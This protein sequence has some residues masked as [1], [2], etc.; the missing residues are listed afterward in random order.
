MRHFDVLD[1]QINQRVASMAKCFFSLLPARCKKSPFFRNLGL[2]QDAAPITAGGAPS[3]WRWTWGTATPD[4]G[5]GVLPPTTLSPT[6][7]RPQFWRP[8]AA[9]AD[10]L[11]L[12]RGG[13][14][15]RIAPLALL[16]LGKADQCVEFLKGDR[17]LRALYHGRTVHCVPQGGEP[18]LH[19]LD[20]TCRQEARVDHDSHPERLE[21][22]RGDQGCRRPGADAKPHVDTQGLGDVPRH[23]GDVVL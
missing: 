20:G 13:C 6:V 16:Q 4:E 21:L 3:P 12:W 9:S 17:E 11:R 23:D 8:S 2:T 10:G 22:R 5:T 14:R 18:V 1:C 15:R 19:A 7:S